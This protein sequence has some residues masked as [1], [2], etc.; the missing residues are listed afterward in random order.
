M[1][2][3]ET[4]RCLRKPDMFAFSFRDSKNKACSDQIRDGRNRNTEY[5]LSSPYRRIVYMLPYGSSLIHE[6]EA[7][8]RH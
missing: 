1:T 2:T 3:N 4:F 7:S 8:A 5:N 6:D